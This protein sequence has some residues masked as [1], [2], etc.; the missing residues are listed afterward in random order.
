MSKDPTQKPKK[1]LND[2][3]RY[4]GLGFQMILLVLAGVFGGKKLDKWLGLNHVFFVIL[5]IVAVFLSMYM[6][7]RE[8]LKK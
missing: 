4:S 3:A 2:Y 6:L 7:I 1:S 5:P 8:F